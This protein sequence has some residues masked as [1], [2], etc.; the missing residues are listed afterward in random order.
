[1]INPRDDLKDLFY[2]ISRNKAFIHV[3]KMVS[4]LNETQRDPRLNE[5]LHPLYT[6]D[7]DSGMCIYNHLQIICV[8]VK[9]DYNN[10]LKVRMTLKSFVLKLRLLCFSKGE[11]CRNC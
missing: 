4:W 10:L 7:K 3:S 9:I 6:T 1:M 11:K 2:K 5:L 8:K